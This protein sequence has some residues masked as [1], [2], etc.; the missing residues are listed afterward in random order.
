MADKMADGW[1]SSAVNHS[2]LPFVLSDAHLTAHLHFVD[3]SAFGAEDENRRD[4]SLIKNALT[5][6]ASQYAAGEKQS[7]GPQE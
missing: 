6:H 1:I 3:Q 5:A 4:I 2:S 7:W